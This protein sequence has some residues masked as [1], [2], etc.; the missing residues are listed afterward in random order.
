MAMNKG[1]STGTAILI[2]APVINEYT[3]ISPLV[4]FSTIGR[5]TSIDAEPGSDIASR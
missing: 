1:T 2:T 4:T 3:T 5:Q